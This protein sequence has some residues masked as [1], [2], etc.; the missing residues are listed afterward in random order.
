MC[1]SPTRLSKKPWLEKSSKN[2]PQ[3]AQ[4]LPQCGQTVVRDTK[5]MA[6]FDVLLPLSN[7]QFL[8][9][10]FFDSLNDLRYP[11]VGGTWIT[12]L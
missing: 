7:D 8:K 2:L 4:K 11:Q 3:Q 6:L 12:S 10:D 1:I 5:N 9:W